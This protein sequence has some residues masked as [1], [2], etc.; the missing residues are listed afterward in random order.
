M[1]TQK[2]RNAQYSDDPEV[3]GHGVR[4]RG[5]WGYEMQDYDT[6]DENP[7]QNEQ[8]SNSTPKRRTALQSVVI[9]LLLIC[10]LIL[11]SASPLFAVSDIEV[12]GGNFYK[13]NHIIDLSG[14]VQGQNGFSALMGDDLLKIFALRCGDAERRIAEACPY[15]KSVHVRY[16][17]PD[18]IEIKLEERSKSVVVPYIESGLLIDEEGFVVDIIKSHRQT[19]LPVIKG[20]VF[21]KYELGKKLAVR[22]EK[23]LELVL[24]IINALRQ[25]DRDTIEKLSYEIES[26]DISDIN[27]IKLPLK[28]GIMVNIGNGDDIY[29]RISATK[30][31]IFSGLE[32]GAKGIVDF[33]NN[34]K[35]IFIPDS[36]IVN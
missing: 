21:D 33:T 12:R 11:I 8:A 6:Q 2:T 10:M 19:D 32:P 20:F 5:D 17:L 15:V 35:P 28:S 34:A 4:E 16:T 26:I 9:A 36:N 27:S 30:E 31:I 23:S 22:D 29:Y 18:K 13:D 25:A 7:P 1:N 3:K 24:T 14:I